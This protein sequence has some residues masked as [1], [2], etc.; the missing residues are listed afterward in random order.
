MS[1]RSITP[2]PQKIMICGRKPSTSSSPSVL[3]ALLAVFHRAYALDP[4]KTLR[5]V[6]GRRK[7]QHVGNLRQGG[8]GLGQQVQ[9]FP[10]AAGEQVIDGGRAVFP[11][12]GVG[13]V[14]FADMGH[15]SQIVKG[16]AFLKMIFNVAADDGAFFAGFAGSR[17]KGDGELAVTHQKKQDD[18]QKVLAD[19]IVTGQFCLDLFEEIAQIK[20]DR[21]PAVLKMDNRVAVA[22][23]VAGDRFQAVHSHHDVLQRMALG[24]DLGVLDAGVDDNHVVGADR[25]RF[26]GCLQMAGAAGDKKHLGTGMRV[27]RRVPFGAVAGNTH[28]KKL[29][30]GTIHGVDGQGIK[31]ITAGTHRRGQVSFLQKNKGWKYVAGS[32]YQ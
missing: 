20:K 21:F 12:E 30:N 2:M 1:L 23:V 14:I 29:C 26:A 15:R 17:H 5:E 24:T 8:A 27:Q 11:A 22:A 3:L 16:Q 7:P 13:Q 18:L 10:D 28:I 6:A 32:F 31:D 4:A 25:H 9:A 19:R